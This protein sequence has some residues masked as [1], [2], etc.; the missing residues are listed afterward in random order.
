M[1]HLARDTLEDLIYALVHIDFKVWM[2]G[3]STRRLARPVDRLLPRGKGPC[4]FTA[5]GDV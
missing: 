3:R 1:S 4:L 2:R 5:F